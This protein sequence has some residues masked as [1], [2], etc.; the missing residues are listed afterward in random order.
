MGG[1]PYPFRV[2]SQVDGKPGTI[3]LDQ[4]RSV[5]QSRLVRRLGVLDEEAGRS[6]LRLLREV[7]AD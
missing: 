6:L 3:L 1:K 5:D 4:I 7:F 2:F